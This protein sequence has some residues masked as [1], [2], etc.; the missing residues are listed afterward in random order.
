MLKNVSIGLCLSSLLW[1]SASAAAQ[2]NGTPR[3]APALNI[4]G[5][6]WRMSGVESV[7]PLQL[8]SRGSRHKPAEYLKF[9]DGAIEGSSGCGQLRGIYRQEDAQLVI[10]AEWRDRE[11]VPC[12]DDEKEQGRSVLNALSHVR[13][14]EATAPKWHLDTLELVDEQGKLQI[15]LW[16]TQSGADLS[17]LDDTFWHLKLLSGSEAD[18]S[19]V[20]VYIWNGAITFSSPSVDSSYSFTYRWLGMEFHY[21]YR[22]QLAE[23][24]DPN[25]LQDQQLRTLYENTLRDIQSYELNAGRL[26]FFNKGRRPIMVLSDFPKEGIENRT[27]RIAKYRGDGTQLS[28]ENGLVESGAAFILFLNGRVTGSPGC[29]GWW[30]AFKVS[31]DRLKVD[32][33]LA[34]AGTCEPEQFTED[35]LVVNAFKGELRVTKQDDRIVLRESNGRPRIVLVPY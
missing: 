32:A 25:F 8:P 19:S 22:T 21:P 4:E 34:L 35:D 11:E 2:E 15:M 17:E 12:N 13:R 6:T 14:I 24:D 33:E 30:G 27:W 29:G 31:G 28:D 26:T 1:V 23:K 16:P 20:V 10:S 7:R 9:Q 5:R 18:F 3:A